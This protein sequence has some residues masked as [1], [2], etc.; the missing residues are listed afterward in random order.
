MFALTFSFPAGRYHATPWGK[1]VNEADVAW[2]P[3]PWRILRALIASYWRKGNRQRW[4]END[5][6]NLI[7]ALAGEPP[8]YYLPKRV[9]HAHTRHYMPGQKMKKTLIFDA[10]AHLSKGEE[11]VV[12]WPQLELDSDLLDLAADLAESIGYLGRAESWVDCKATRHWEGEANCLP[13]GHNGE[14]SGEAVRV[15]AARNPMEYAEKRES[16]LKEAEDA[17]CSQAAASGKRPPTPS[18]LKTVRKKTFGPTLP[19]RLLDALTLDT[20]DYQKY[21]WNQPPASREMVYI[22]PPLSPVPRRVQI[23]TSID[24]RK[25][26]TVARYLL[27]GRPRPRIEDAVKIGELMRLAALSKFG[28]KNRRPKAPLVISGRSTDGRPLRRRRHSHAF[29]LP[30]DADGDGWIDHIS[31][32]ADE[33]FNAEVREK[34]DRVTRLWVGRNDSDGSEGNER[35]AYQEWRLALEGFG[36][37]KEFADTSKLFG[38]SDKWVSVTPFLSAGHLKKDG[39]EG[40]VNRLLRLREIATGSSAGFVKV[41]LLPYIEVCG[42]RRRPVH[43]HRFRSC[44]REKQPDAQGAFLRLSFPNP[45]E[46]PLALGYGCHFGLGMFARE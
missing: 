46:G 45:I 39:Y 12:V 13:V 34:L 26:F 22:R 29:W 3:E 4:S 37:P 7:D 15:F 6:S 2:P 5:L 19:E 33:G 27:A 35:N 23:R 31:V 17:A 44:G 43:F 21:R 8:S 41:K 18:A 1:Q 30:E 36:N 28:W 9:V 11:I 16:L 14:T 20:A 24:D 25:Q 32:Y 40:E 38:F 10:F 42:T